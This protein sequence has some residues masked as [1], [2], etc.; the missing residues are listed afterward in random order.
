MSDTTPV[1][2]VLFAL[3]LWPKEN[4]FAGK[5]YKHLIDWKNLQEFFPWQLILSWQLLHFRVHSAQTKRTRSSIDCR[6][7]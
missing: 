5:P 4:I 6:I 7:D 3:S 2:L 1:I